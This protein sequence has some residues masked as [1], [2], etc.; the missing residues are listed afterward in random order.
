M[1]CEVFMAAE[2]AGGWGEEKKTQSVRLHLAPSFKSKCKSQKSNTISYQIMLMILMK[3][4]GI[5]FK[6]VL[7]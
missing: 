2:L 6:S 3:A 5:L 4:S 1:S 7:V